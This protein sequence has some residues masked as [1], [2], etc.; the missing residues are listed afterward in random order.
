MEAYRVRVRLFQKQSSFTTKFR[1]AVHDKNRFTTL[2]TDLKDLI[3]QLRDVTSSIA[4]LEKQ[5][6][7][8][9]AEIS[10]LSDSHSLDVLE[11]ALREDDP[12]LSEVA[13]QRIVQLTEA[14][15]NAGY[16]TFGSE[17]Q[18]VT[19]YSAVQQHDVLDDDVSFDEPGDEPDMAVSDDET[20]ENESAALR[21]LD[22]L[23]P[24]IGGH[25][26]LLYGQQNNLKV[27]HEENKVKFGLVR[28]TTTWPIRDRSVMRQMKQIL[29]D[30][31]GL[32]T[33]GPESDSFSSLLAAVQGPSGTPYHG[34]VFFIRMRI[35]R[36][37]PLA[38]PVCHFLT[39]VLHPNIASD[40]KIVIDVLS[41]WDRW[42]GGGWSLLRDPAPAWNTTAGRQLPA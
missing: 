38:P 42:S 39:P 25:P 24:T 8:I 27:I 12:G 36:D 11:E 41:P 23:E 32:V 40:G 37:F 33:L 18:Y 5:R 1:W 6:Q 17:S 3:D 26:D 29:Q 2:V 34:G 22:A 15:T 14:G 21:P 16:L 10:S 31:D 35:P 7:I 4:D 13:S 19:A 9:A 30:T 28:T 20:Q